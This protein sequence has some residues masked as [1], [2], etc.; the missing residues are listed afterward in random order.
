MD[1]FAARSRIAYLA[2]LL[3]V[4]LP[5]IGCQGL[6][7]TALYLI[8][9]FDVDP[10]FK[11]LKGKTVAVVCRATETYSNTNVS[12]ELATE[13]AKL[14]REKVPKI[15]VIDQQKVADWMD[16]NTWEEYTEV[17]KAVKA[18]MVVAIDLERFSDLASQ[19]LYQGKANATVMV[20]DCKH[21]GKEVFRRR[22][23]QLVYP[24]SAPVQASERD[25]EDAFRREFVG[26]LAGRI[27]Q[28]FYAHDP[29]ADIGEDAVALGVRQ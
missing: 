7:L 17:G 27:G 19:T 2:A 10:D 21:G 16:N 14:L 20:Y 13:V 4:A 1:R 29:H 11:D 22:L 23:P 25:S 3:V 9:G 24:R 15:K 28:Y 26:V 12:R 6:S 18:D 5:A 8:K